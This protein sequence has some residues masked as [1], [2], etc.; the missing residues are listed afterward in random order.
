MHMNRI[1]L[2]MLLLISCS[3]HISAQTDYYYYQGKK[4]PL[5]RN[6]EKVVVSIPKENVETSRRISA[7]TQILSTI[8][9][10]AFDIR[11]ISRSDFEK[12]A[13]QDFWEEDSKYVILT[14]CYFTGSHEEVAATP[15]LNVRLKSEEDKSLLT[16]YVEQFN[17]KITWNSPL[18]PLWYILAITPESEK[19]SLEC[20]N[21][22]Y[23]SGAFASSVPDFAS[24]NPLEPDKVQEKMLSEGKVWEYYSVH[25]ED[26]DET[27]SGEGDIEKTT[28]IVDFTLTGDTVI[29]SHQ[30]HKVYYR[31][32]GAM[33]SYYSAVREEGTTVYNVRRNETTETV[34]IEFD[35]K[36]FGGT[37]MDFIFDGAEPMETIDSIS[38]GGRQF[39]RHHYGVKDGQQGM[40]EYF[41]AVEGVGYKD[42]GLILGM[43][44]E[45]PTCYC[46]YMTFKACYEN[47]VCIFTNEDFK[48]A[49]IT[50]SIKETLRPVI[51]NIPK[52]SATF[53]LQGRRINGELKRGLYIRDGKK[54]IKF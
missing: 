27:G 54:V 16:S 48:A 38:V 36:R 47:G 23:E 40:T 8:S 29:G 11:I 46:D 50:S 2:L 19:N 12:L 22:L 37:V 33:P 14:S 6:E 1:Y 41:V 45:R 4:I 34:L 7:N 20:A 13:S 5:T 3:L 9:D 32:E 31:Q 39:R 10:D 26:S 44:F 49:P 51:T 17:L 28:S 21:A 42:N 30:Y 43:S 52:S 53:D 24:Y 18:M 25:Y 15:Y 35:P